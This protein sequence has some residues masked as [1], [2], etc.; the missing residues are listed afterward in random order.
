M[1][2]LCCCCCTNL[3]VQQQQHK[4]FWCC[5]SSRILLLPLLFHREAKFSALGRTDADIVAALIAK[6]QDKGVWTSFQTRSQMLTLQRGRVMKQLQPTAPAWK[7]TPALDQTSKYC[8]EGGR[9]YVGGVGQEL[10]EPLEV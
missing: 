9:G 1:P 6:L 3:L 4:S 2:W 5:E 8:A 7:S 10:A